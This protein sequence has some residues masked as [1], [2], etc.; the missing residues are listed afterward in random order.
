VDQKKKELNFVVQCNE[1]T[2]LVTC[3]ARSRHLQVEVGTS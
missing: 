2:G 1:T 3:T